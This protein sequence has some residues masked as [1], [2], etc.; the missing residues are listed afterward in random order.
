MMTIKNW[1]NIH[2]LLKTIPVEWSHTI[3]FGLLHSP[4]PSETVRRFLNAVKQVMAL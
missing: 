2:P 3:P 1:K 4:R